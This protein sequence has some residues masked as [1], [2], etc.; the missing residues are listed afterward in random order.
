MVRGIVTRPIFLHVQGEDPGTEF[1]KGEE[2]GPE[3]ER[4][5][6]YHPVQSQIRSGGRSKKQQ[7][8]PFPK[9]L[10]KHTPQLVLLS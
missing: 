7:A 3:G 4:P 10:P 5:G 8:P 6:R 1:L 9:D 2:K